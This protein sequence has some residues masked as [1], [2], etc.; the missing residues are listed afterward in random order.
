[1]KPTLLRLG[2]KLAKKLRLRTSY[3]RLLI[4]CFLP[5]VAIAHLGSSLLARLCVRLNEDQQGL[6]YLVLLPGLIGISFMLI[7]FVYQRLLARPLPP[8]FVLRYAFPGFVLP[9]NV[10]MVVAHMAPSTYAE[11]VSDQAW[12]TTRFFSYTWVG[13]LCLSALFVWGLLLHWV[14]AD[15]KAHRAGSK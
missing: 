5:A 14:R 3:T 1:M 7:L 9:P 11:Q 10:A 12:Q 4:S 2:G 15:S 6:V 8:R 13:T